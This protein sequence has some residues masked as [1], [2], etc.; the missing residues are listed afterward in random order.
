MSVEKLCRV[1]FCLF[2]RVCRRMGVGVCSVRW[3][4]EGAQVFLKSWKYFDKTCTDNE[5]LFSVI[6]NTMMLSWQPQSDGNTLRPYLLSS[7]TLID[8]R[9]ACRE[10]CLYSRATF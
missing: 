7:T 3:G 6:S 8:I 4:G 2:V 10:T 1:C 5:G 9:V